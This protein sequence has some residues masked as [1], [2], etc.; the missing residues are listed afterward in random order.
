MRFL[1]SIF[2]ISMAL[3]ASAEDKTVTLSVDDKPALALQVP[4]AA[5]LTSSKNYVNI[6]TTNMSLHVWFVPKAQTVKAAEMRAAKL[7]KSEF[8]NF[9]TSSAEDLV[10]ADAPARH[11]TGSGDEADDGDPGHAEVIFFVVGGHVFAACVHGEFDDAARAR[12]P[13][14][15]VLQTAHVAP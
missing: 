15:A 13:M 12:A 14:M 4:S 3:R 7:I 8:V 5:K 1:A 11:V 9:K 6:R 10:I 2:I